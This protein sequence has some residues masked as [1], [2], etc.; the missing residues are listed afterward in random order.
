M[1]ISCNCSK[2][3]KRKEVIHGTSEDPYAVRTLLGWSMVGPVATSDSSSE[4]HALNSTCHRTLARE[5]VP[6]DR[7]S[8]SSF[9]LKGRTKELINPI[10]INK[11]F[12]LDFSDHK[13]SGGH[14]LSKEDRRF[15]E[16]VEQGIHQC[17]DRRYELPLPLK[18]ERIELPNNRETALRR[19]N[20]LKRRF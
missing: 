8:R 18:T 20:Q 11:M 16:I 1:L 6:G 13:N 12:E 15:Q 2:A 10:A 19:L 9:V 5:R 14:G 17:E 4:D 3:I 7:E